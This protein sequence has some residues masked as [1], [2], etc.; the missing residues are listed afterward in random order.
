MYEAEGVRHIC[1]PNLPSEVAN[2]ASRAFGAS[3]LPYLFALADGVRPAL[4]RSDALRN[5]CGF[6][7]GHMVSRSLRKFV[8]AP[9]VDLDA[10]IPRA[11]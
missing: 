1:I 11:E 9:L 7:E 3:L 2:T 6:V 4:S 8:E 10:L 5:A